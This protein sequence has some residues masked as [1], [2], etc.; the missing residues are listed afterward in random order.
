MA[1]LAAVVLLGRFVGIKAL[2]T[3]V[4]AAKPM[5]FVTAVAFLLG[6]G[7][8]V[9][10][11]R[12]RETAG[13]WLG[14]AV[15]AIGGGS[16]VLYAFAGPLGLATFSL[17]APPVSTGFGFDGRMS[18]NAAA[19]FLTWGLALAA[20]KARRPFTRT[21]SAVAALLIAV[22]FLAICGYV[23]R[24]DA[25]SQWWRYSAMAIHTA[26]GLVVAG[27][28]IVAWVV[29]HA[30]PADRQM[31][32]TVPLFATAAGL[33]L[34]VG[35]ISYFSNG[36]LIHAGER[37]TR[38]F[39]VQAEVDRLVAEVARMESSARGFALTGVE[40]FRTRVD[41]H[42]REIL[43]Q[44]D[45][46]RGLEADN[47]IQLERVERL[48][49]LAEQKFAQS[50]S[51]VSARAEGGSVEAARLLTTLPAESG[52]ALVNLADD[53]RAE[54]Q[55]QLA[56]RRAEMALIQDGT[57]S[58]RWI[59]GALALGLAGIALTIERRA[60]AAEAARQN[61]EGEVRASRER[62]L[63]IFGAV[64]DGI[65]FQNRRGEIE[66]C[67]A[68][69]ERM[70]GL[71]RDQLMGRTSFDPQWRAFH[72]DGTPCPPERHPAVVTLRT[73]EPVRGFVMAVQR[74]DGRRVW[75]SINTEPLRDPDGGVQAVVVSFADITAHRQATEAQRASE[76][77]FR[78][79]SNAAFEGIV[80]SENGRILDANDQAFALFGA[81][82]AELIG[83]AILDFVAPASRPAVAEAVRAGSE[84]AYEHQLLRK[85]GTLFVVEARARMLRL[86][87]RHLRMTALRDITA[88]KQ[89]ESD[90]RVARDQ[91]LAAS[92]LK[93]EFLATMSHEIRTP[94][95]GII[96][97]VSLL[98]DTRLDAEQRE[99]GRIIQN[100]AE[101][102]LTIVNDIL[103]FSKIE[104]GMLRMAPEDFE[105]RPVVEETLALLAPRAHEKK[106]ELV[107][108]F[109][110]TL[111]GSLSGDA[112]RIRQV[113][114]N[115]VS[116]ALKFTDAGEVVV[117]IR[118]VREA[119]GRKRIRF[120]V[121]DTGIGIPAEAQGRLF[122]AFTQ[123][124]GTVTRRFGG[125]G[126]GLAI[127]RQLV[128]LMGGEI[129]LESTAG[130]G[131]LFWFE[132]E[133]AAGRA[134]PP[135]EMPAA[136]PPGL[137][138]LVVDDNEANRGVLLGLLAQAGVEAE[139]VADAA[140]AWARLRAGGPF[141]LVLLDWHLPDRS[142][143]ELAVEIRAD[144]ALAQLP[145]VMMS[146]AGATDDSAMAA[147][148]RF[149]AYLPKPVRAAQLRRCLARAANRPEASAASAPRTDRAPAGGGLRLLL[150]EDNVAN[151]MV[152][153][154][155]LE[156]MGHAIDIVVDG[157]QALAMLA[158]RTY[159]AVLMDCQMPV[160][161]GYETTRRIR[162]GTLPG[163]NPRVPVI[164][165]TAYAMEDDRRKCVNAG[166]DDYVS[167]PVRAAELSAAL[168]R[169]GLRTSRV[170]PPPS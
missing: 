84:G 17:A 108:D 126:L 168:L 8:L 148:V 66:E 163:V 65:V 131:S 81:D 51:M 32:R 119:G 165:L 137:R 56:V 149:E 120:E 35:S 23:M 60:A 153:R 21:L 29:T 142:G 155:L 85:D 164:A 167:K 94:M 24:L 71:T 31:A 170:A 28:G 157:R 61:A 103:D 70:L 160:L 154:L 145:L 138:V 150:A 6:G 135:A 80:I 127:S 19:S 30:P 116:N 122:Q 109:D 147:E 26:A 63:R 9:A 46:L 162:A 74:A 146:S 166:M 3:V 134:L 125:T 141:H 4:P 128:E 89:L 52:S 59:A 144:P 105:L 75:V 115:L 7:A 139:A 91:A 92:R 95:N 73:G 18:P 129:G 152:A 130:R 86:G 112:G 45:A 96:G 117:R 111:D 5:A 2:V 88:R 10:H 82:R 49:V 113:L 53:I 48:H 90:L 118:P 106:L 110:R 98:V 42:R 34:A 79:L 158:E 50:S 121:R 83:R 15:A 123:I 55:R 68:A 67:N 36:E 161:D 169:C 44:L 107:C 43:R 58:V 47:G 16:L 159:D 77:R 124:D 101:N 64:A 57:R 93:S 11:A 78:T 136:L 69:A 100:S 37:V 72:E 104:A 12:G 76:E 38:T 97:M 39:Q 156:K 27:S 41:D 87:D 62:R 33:M 132:L 143:F 20:M 114:T 14:A 25:S 40:L 102:L 13:R 54:E 133:F 1:A 99:M 22:A 151:Q 140:A